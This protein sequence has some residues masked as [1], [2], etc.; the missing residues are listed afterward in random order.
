MIGRQ[1]LLV[2]VVLGFGAALIVLR[3]VFFQP[4]NLPS[5]SMS[6]TVNM[7]DYFFVSLRA[8][9][10]RDPER[11]DVIVFHLP[12]GDFVKRITGIPGDTV[13]MRSGRLYLNGK[14]VP[15][16]AAAPYVETDPFGVTHAIPCFKETLPSGVSYYVLDRIPDSSED[17]TE[18]FHVP[19]DHY[20]VMGDNRDNSDDSRLDLGYIARRDIVGRVAVKFVD[21]RRHTLSWAPVN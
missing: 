15:K 8:F 11:G 2:G 16:E 17:S 3:F 19:P 9:T 20:F 6:P 4:F 14:P 1:R 12:K 7:G 10:W 13:Q 5:E 21:G 18:V